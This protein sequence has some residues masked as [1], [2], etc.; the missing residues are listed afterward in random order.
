MVWVLLLSGIQV[1]FKWML[2]VFFSDCCKEMLQVNKGCGATYQKEVSIG[3]ISRC[4]ICVSTL[5]GV[6]Y[7]FTT[8]QGVPVQTTGI[9]TDGRYLIVGPTEG[10]SMS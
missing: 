2:G 5:G 10:N 4:I 3:S 7:G 1:S 8:T 6:P 9:S